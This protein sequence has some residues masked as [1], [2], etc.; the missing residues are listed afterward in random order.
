MVN[1]LQFIIVF[2]LFSGNLLA[3]KKIISTF[4]APD[5]KKVIYQG[6]ILYNNDKSALM[7]SASSASVRF[8]GTKISAI[9]Q[10]T[11]GKNYYNVIIDYDSITLLQPGKEKKEYVLAENLPYGE[12]IVELFKRSEW[13]MGTTYIYGFN[14]V[15]KALKPRNKKKLKLE[16]YGNSITSACGVEDYSGKDRLDTIFTNSYFSYASFTARALNADYRIISKGGIGI[17]ISWFPLIMPE[18]Y[19]RLIPTNA[20]SY[21]NFKNYTPDIVIINLL[22]NDSWLIKKP[23]HPEFIHRF[24][25]KAPPENEIVSAYKNF[26]SKIRKE[27]PHAKIICMLGN[28][29]ATRKGSPWPQYI[30]Q[31]VNVMHDKNIFTL[32]VPYKNTPGHPKI[33]EQKAMADI[34]TRFIK[35]KVLQ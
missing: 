13:S 35:Q 31:A 18:L 4:V 19:Y 33:E 1:F 7:W 28:M 6:R 5:D 20:N 15:G 14:I 16:F 24:G 12:H 3:Q 27:Y 32:F 2:F 34:L 8:K 17:M 30:K 22:Q 25:R 26:V 10:D 9:L 11:K 21:H 23:N 29:D